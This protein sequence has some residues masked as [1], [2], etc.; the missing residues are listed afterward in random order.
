MIVPIIIIRYALS[1]KLED[2]ADYTKAIKIKG[3]YF[4]MK[5]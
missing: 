1:D 2:F 4:K 3:N 5:I